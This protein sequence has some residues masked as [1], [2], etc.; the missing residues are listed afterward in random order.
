MQILD[1][2][3]FKGEKQNLA[4]RFLTLHEIKFACQILNSLAFQ[5]F[6]S[7]LTISHF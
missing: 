7:D 4:T 3:E 1:D 6:E 2:K 5:V